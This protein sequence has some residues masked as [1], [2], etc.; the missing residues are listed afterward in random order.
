MQDETPAPDES[1]ATETP[2]TETKT[3]ST[4]ES[5]TPASRQVS[6]IV[7]TISFII[8][9]LL[10][11]VIFQNLFP[12]GGGGGGSSKGNATVDVLR[13]DIETQRA[14]INR[15]RI[16]LGMEPLEG[17]SGIETAEEVAARLKADADTL[18]SLTSSYQDLLERKEAQLDELRAESI[19]ALKDQQLLREQLNRVNQDLRAA[20]VD[21]SLATTLKGDLDKAN[22]QIKALQEELQRSRD[23]PS[24]LRA[25]LIQCN[26]ERNR[27]LA[28]VAELEQQLRKVTLF[29]SSED[30]LIKE[31]VALFRALRELQGATKSE[32]ASAYSRFGAE[33]GATVLQTCDFATGSAEVRA[34]LEAQLRML[35][36][37]IPENAMIFVV[38]YAS[39]TGNVD[40][41]QTLSSDR[42]TAVARVL[43]TIKR[44]TQRV[45]AV[46]LGQ[47]KR[48]SREVPEENQR[49]EVWQIV[50]QGL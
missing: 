10:G 2:A 44:P 40:S 7:L 45:Q 14:E 28:Q 43:D 35:P 42:A 49:V 34:D 18:A 25:Q 13:A 22:A 19:K 36:S 21:A 4:N 15:Q 5:A 1:S 50:P 26:T 27:L 12:R 41:N 3:E 37:E 6:P 17:T 31:A 24:E 39:E 38:G 32:L 23:E 16:A 20:M 46:Y 9:T 47:T 29:A 8:I 11:I 48:F 30:E 33:L